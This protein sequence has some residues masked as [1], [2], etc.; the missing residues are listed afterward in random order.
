M[1]HPSGLAF[2][3]EEG[4]EQSKEQIGDL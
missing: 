2:N 4:K 3:K 1:D